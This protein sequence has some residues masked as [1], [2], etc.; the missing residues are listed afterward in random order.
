MLGKGDDMASGKNYR[1][2]RLATA[3]LLFLTVLLICGFAAPDQNHEAK[4]I[5]YV[6]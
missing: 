6:T 5:F 1:K 4:V 2:G 3:A